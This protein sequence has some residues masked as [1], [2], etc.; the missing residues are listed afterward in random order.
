MA[1]IG[2]EE[3]TYWNI[4]EVGKYGTLYNPENFHARFSLKNRL[5]YSLV[6]PE[7]M[8]VDF[9]KVTDLMH[10]ILASRKEK[11]KE[12]IRISDGSFLI[13]SELIPVV[14]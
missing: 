14:R 3:K 13:K 9:L 6:I 7:D 4:G 2:F 11:M 8:T 5:E 12:M 1:D 10:Q